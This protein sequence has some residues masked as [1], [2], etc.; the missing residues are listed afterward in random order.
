RTLIT[1]LRHVGLPR[2]AEIRGKLV[3]T[4]EPVELHGKIV[5]YEYTPLVANVTIEANGN[6]WKVGGISSYVEDVE[7]EK[8]MLFE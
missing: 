8:F 6:R 2:E 3:D 7:G 4:R 1:V 5:D